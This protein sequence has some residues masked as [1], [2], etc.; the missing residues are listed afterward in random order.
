M[1]LQLEG[2]GAQLK[3]TDGH[4]VIDKLIQGGAADKQGELKVGD[5]VVSVGQGDEGAM[6]DVGEMKLND[7]V[8]LIRG[9]AG[10]TVKLGVIGAAGG[11]VKIVKIVRAKIELKDSEARGEIIEEGTKSD[12]TA[13][14]IGV[15]DLPSF[16]MDMSRARDGS[17]NFK[18]CSRDVR[19]ILDD[20][21]AKGVD[22]VVLDLRRNGGGSLTE[23]IHLTGFFIEDGPVLQVKDPDG[24][25]QQYDDTDRGIAWKGPL[26]V[27]TSKF[28]ASASEI[29][30]G[31]IQ[32]YKRGLVIGD[33]AT[34]GKGTVQTMVDLGSQMFR[35]SNPPELGSLKLTIQQFYRPSGDS[36]QQRGVLADVTLPSLTDHMD[37]A[38]GDLDYP[39]AFDKV[40]AAPF[41]S[42]DTVSGD[43]V[44]TLKNLAGQRVEQSAEFKKLSRDIERYLEQKVKKEVPLN[45]EKFFAR[46]AE[47]D[48]ESEEEKTFEQQANGSGDKQVFKR[49]YYNNEVLNI[50]LDYLRLLGKDK[51]A[52]N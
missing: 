19:R 23:A 18:S 30:A 6:V 34:H 26:V 31:A 33:S 20:F 8:K 45:E 11:D 12:G 4:T 44:G 50:T 39:V 13:F 48:A 40:P 17:E 7:V 1:G 3:L 9:R 24:R 51:V 38:E 43:I 16:Y 41:R 22:A 37:V 2:I 42:Y 46:R 15:I 35:I 25:V 5:R 10:S 32:D 27:L 36:T 28:S 21:N 29:L 52:R 47:L 14:K 49:N